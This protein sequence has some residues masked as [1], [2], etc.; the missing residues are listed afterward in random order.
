MWSVVK[1]VLF[2]T[3]VYAVTAF[4]YGHHLQKFSCV[5]LLTQDRGTPEEMVAPEIRGE[6]ELSSWRW[7][8]KWWDKP[9][10]SFQLV[11][12]PATLR[13]PLVLDGD[14]TATLSEPDDGTSLQLDIESGKFSG[15]ID[16]RN[17]FVGTCS[18]Q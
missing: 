12:G 7:F 15:F 8:V 17:E 1:T 10:A 16:R 9:V 13:A 3:F 4:Y 5:G 11:N 14:R 6:L 2:V 18:R